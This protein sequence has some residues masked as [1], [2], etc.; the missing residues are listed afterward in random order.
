MA[1]NCIEHS[2]VCICTHMTTGNTASQTAVN[3]CIMQNACN[4]I[5]AGYISIHCFQNRYH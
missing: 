4:E 2:D 5:N 3:Y 1:V